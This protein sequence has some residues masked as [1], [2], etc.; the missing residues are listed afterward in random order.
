MW[1]YSYAVLE[2]LNSLHDACP[3]VIG[4][5]LVYRNSVH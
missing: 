4:Q 3:T 5:V 2:K 1:I